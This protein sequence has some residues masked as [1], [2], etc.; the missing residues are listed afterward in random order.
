MRD[1][2]LIYDRFTEAQ[3]RKMSYDKQRHVAE[4][5]QAEY[6]WNAKYWPVTVGG[7]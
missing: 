2:H 6:F 4:R 1:K 3:W 5:W 7:I